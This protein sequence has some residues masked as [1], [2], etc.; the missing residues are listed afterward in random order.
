MNMN[1]RKIFLIIVAFTFAT[2]FF[3]PSA[4]QSQVSGYQFNGITYRTD[5]SGQFPINIPTPGITVVIKIYKRYDQDVLVPITGLTGVSGPDG[6]LAMEVPCFPSSNEDF[7]E[8]V[9]Y[10]GA[11]NADGTVGAG[12]YF[13]S[14]AVTR[15]IILAVQFTQTTRY[16][17]ILKTQGQPV[18]TKVSAVP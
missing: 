3:S 4:A 10:T 17:E 8:T 11:L 16:S 12:P 7:F 13:N 15:Q 2:L 14:Q 9:Y 6:R 1:S 5:R 18:P